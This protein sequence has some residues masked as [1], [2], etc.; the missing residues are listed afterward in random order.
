MMDHR[1]RHKKLHE[2]LD[3]LAACYMLSTGKRVSNTTLLELLEWS[4][5]ATLD[6]GTCAKRAERDRMTP[7]PADLCSS[8]SS[9]SSQSTPPFHPPDCQKPDVGAS[10]TP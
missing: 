1:E 10:F 3:E 2:A 6:A 7:S 4:H 8:S 9:R 5:K